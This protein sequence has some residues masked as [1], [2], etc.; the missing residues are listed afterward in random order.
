MIG[1][2]ALILIG[3]FSGGNED[4]LIESD[5]EEVETEPVLTEAEQKELE[6]KKSIKAQFHF[7]DGSHINLT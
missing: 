3:I 7:W 4:E 6:R 1:I 2:V 5:K